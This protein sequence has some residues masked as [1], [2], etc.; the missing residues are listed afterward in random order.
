MG[1]ASLE[2]ALKLPLV[3]PLAI[4][5]RYIISTSIIFKPDQRTS[6]CRV[7]ELSSSILITLL[8]AVSMTH[9]ETTTSGLGW[10]TCF[11]QFSEARF[12]HEDDDG[13]MA[14]SS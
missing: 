13:N 11:L 4:N 2:V 10:P 1:S 5:L 6:C 7:V 9:Q 8:V 14:I 3:V 12:E